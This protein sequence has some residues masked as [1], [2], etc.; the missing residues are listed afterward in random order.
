MATATHVYAEIL[1]ERDPLEVLAETQRTIP[2]LAQTLGAEGLKRSYAPGKWTAAEILAHLA[3]CEIA[4]GFRVRQILT[5]PILGIQPFDEDGWAKHYSE[6]DGVAAAQTYESLRGWNLALFTKLSEEELSR[7]AKHPQR[8]PQSVAT[9]IRIMAG[10]TLHH[11]VHLEKIV[12][13]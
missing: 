6:M 3:D 5:E 11:V 13:G 9:A 8:G 4:F 7:E 2:I 10:H 12:A 1:G